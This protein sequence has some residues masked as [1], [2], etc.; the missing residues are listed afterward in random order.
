M[1]N[2]TPK[3][4]IDLPSYAE[5]ALTLLNNSG[6]EAFVVGG[7]VR[8]SLSNLKDVYDWDIAT[9]ALPEETKKVF[10]GFK[11]AEKGIKHG[12]VTVISDGHP[13]EITTYRTE[14]E[15]ADH[16]HPNA[17][18]FTRS[19]VEDL[20]RRDFTINAMAY[21]PKTG[22]IDP[23]GG[24]GDLSEGVIRCVGDADKRFTEDS[25]RILRA[26]RFASS[27]NMQLDDKTKK[28]AIKNNRLL[29]FVASERAREELTKMLC[30]SNIE[31]VLLK[32][33]EIISAVIPEI[34]P[35][36]GFEQHSPYHNKDVWEH[37]AAVVK[38]VCPVSDLRWAALL[39]DIGKPKCFSV[40]EDGNGHFYG[41]AEISRK[42][43][44]NILN[45]LRFDRKTQNSVLTLVE[46]HD[47]EIVP[48]PKY[49]KKLLR[50]TGEENVK[51]LFCIQR[52]DAMAKSVEGSEML[53][54]IEEAD[55]VLKEILSRKECF[56]LK[57]L[58]VDGNDMQ[59]I[60]LKGEKIG[61]ALEFCL[62]EVIEE[63]AEN[64]KNAL[65]E[66]VKNALF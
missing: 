45:R 61:R 65:L 39:H 21:S 49:I 64:E 12:T 46:L 52:A 53:G 57:D 14:Q 37:T 19:L 31:E 6:Y 55:G 23:F 4:S 5:K 43:A 24:A 10:N 36:F 63:R 66:S 47:I 41:H 26:L 13:L 15:Y 56:S 42:I 44:E 17:V 54:K 30:G 28:A 9:S 8:D 62:N 40:S 11:I 25:L 20:S 29:S 7:A 33:G 59:S 22:I 18:S 32:Y 35:A 2:I 1:D 3:T 60:G 51:K 34:K 48:Q 50:K 16:R 58:A 38:N 27:L